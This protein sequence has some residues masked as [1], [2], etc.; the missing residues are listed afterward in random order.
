MQTWISPPIRKTGTLLKP[1]L[2]QTFGTR[3]LILFIPHF[4]S[5][6]FFLETLAEARHEMA[7]NLEYSSGWSELE[8]VFFPDSHIRGWLDPLSHDDDCTW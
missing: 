1:G 4:L 7:N 2:T 3:K 6:H 8:D 5:Q